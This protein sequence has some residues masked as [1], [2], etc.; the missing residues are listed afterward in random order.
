[1]KLLKLIKSFKKPKFGL[2]GETYV[3]NLDTYQKYFKK[4]PFHFFST[5]LYY[6]I[7]FVVIKQQCPI[8]YSIN[9]TF[10]TYIFNGKSV[11]MKKDTRK[12]SEDDIHYS[13]EF[14]FNKK[15]KIFDDTFKQ[16]LLPSNFDFCNL[17]KNKIS[18]NFFSHDEI[19][20]S[21]KSFIPLTQDDTLL[22]S[23]YDL[24]FVADEKYKEFFIWCCNVE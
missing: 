7:E 16:D 10:E 11:E 21:T 20:K 1:M 22:Q 14:Y 3:M 6:D 9:N 2:I 8:K 5:F 24:N 17:C 23:M 18:C 4:F 19:T 15:K 12:F 13:P